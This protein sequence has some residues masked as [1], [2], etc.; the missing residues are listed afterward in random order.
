MAAGAMNFPPETWAAVV[1][2]LPIEVEKLACHLMTRQLAAY[3]RFG[4]IANVLGL[5]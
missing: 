4:R 1:A 2:R 5:S 3:S